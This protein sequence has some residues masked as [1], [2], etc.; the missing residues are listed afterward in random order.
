MEILW[1]HRHSTGDG[2]SVEHSKR[3][4]RIDMLKV[5]N[6][7]LNVLLPWETIKMKMK[8]KS[9]QLCNEPQ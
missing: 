4:E 7:K 9:E 5:A 1:E 2:Q 6:L 3:Q 8:E